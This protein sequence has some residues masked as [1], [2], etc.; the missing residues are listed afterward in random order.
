MA[1][2]ETDG[3]IAPLRR[4]YRERAPPPDRTEP[5]GTRWVLTDLGVRVPVVPPLTTGLRAI[6]ADDAP[7]R[8]SAR[9]TEII[10]DLAD[11]A[12]V[13]LRSQF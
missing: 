9:F 11:H 2:L 13:I 3:A 1:R 8:P 6:A 7:G 4:A 12:Q 10:T 5:G